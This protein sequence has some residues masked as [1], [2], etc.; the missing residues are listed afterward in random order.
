MEV[1]GPRALG[2]PVQWCAGPSPRLFPALSLSR[3][4]GRG[5]HSL[6]GLS[7]LT[8]GP[9]DAQWEVPV[10][11]LLQW[12]GGRERPGQTLFAPKGP[13]WQQ[14]GIVGRGP[15]GLDPS[16]SS[17]RHSLGAPGAGPSPL[18]TF[19]PPW[20]R[21]RWSAAHQVLSRTTREQARRALPWGLAQSEE[22]TVNYHLPQVTGTRRGCPRGWCHPWCL[23]FIQAHDENCQRKRDPQ[24][25]RKTPP[26]LLFPRANWGV[27]GGSPGTAT[28]W[29][30]ARGA[31]CPA[32]SL[33]GDNGSSSDL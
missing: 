22:A 17:T 25:G 32:T 7:Q 24:R 14:C 19:P 11:M 31:K 3:L 8:A 27:P 6:G 29:S 26:H 23:S 5:S 13:Q 1:W 21:E 2:S 18:R 12:T 16:P 33:F 20:G 15:G 4:Q 9:S 28:A 10:L 30:S